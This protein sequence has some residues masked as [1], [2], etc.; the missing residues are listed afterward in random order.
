MFASAHDFPK[1]V[2]VGAAMEH[3]LRKV[4]TSH[5]GSRFLELKTGPL[6]KG[7]PF[8]HAG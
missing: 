8:I 2:K 5:A 1:F 7:H 4:G 6:G 3:E